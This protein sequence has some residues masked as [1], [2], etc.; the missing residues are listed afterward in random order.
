M[1]LC[2]ALMAQQ[3]SVPLATTAESPKQ[4]LNQQ[5]QKQIADPDKPLITITGLCDTRWN[6][7]TVASDCRTVI[8][9]AQFEKIANAIK[10]NMSLHA[11]HE[12][13]LHYVD[14]LA[15]T[16]RAEQMGLDQGSNYEEQLKLA[17]MQVLSQDLKNTIQTKVSQITDKDIEDYYHSNEE[18]FEEAEIERIYTPK[19]QQP[20]SGSIKHVSNTDG[21][22]QSQELQQRMNQEAS[23]LHARAVAGEEFAKLQAD[24]YEFA[25][26]K[27]VIPNTRMVIRRTSLPPSQVSIMDLR[28]GEISPILADPNGY[29]IYKVKSKDTFP[30]ERVRDE[31]KANLRSQRLQAEMRSIL[32]SAVPVLDESYF[33]R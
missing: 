3:P 24:A 10:P 19:T 31:I 11:Q 26:I 8:T 15:M 30:L 6:P 2:S 28:P 21:E 33:A 13:A 7:N 4:G 9:R 27:S 29:F 32:G 5:A 12:F 23:N 20:A 25:G 1:T 18:N 22:N 17:R 14:V 16:R